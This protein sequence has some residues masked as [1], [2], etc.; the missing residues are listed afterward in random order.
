MQKATMSAT[1]TNSTVAAAV[2]PEGK[3]EVAGVELRRC[4]S[5][6]GRA[7]TKVTERK[8]V[9]SSTSASVRNAASRQRRR[10][11]EKAD[12]DGRRERQREP[13]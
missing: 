11:R 4:T 10:K 1:P 13:C 7:T 5:G 12:D 9:I 8:T 2:W 3:L 6:R